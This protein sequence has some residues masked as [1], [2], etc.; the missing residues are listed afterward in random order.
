MHNYLVGENATVAVV[1]LLNEQSFKGSDSAEH[2]F[3]CVNVWPEQLT[4]RSLE[5]NLPSAAGIRE[6]LFA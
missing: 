3:R 4:I 1:Q 2:W 6:S 5:L